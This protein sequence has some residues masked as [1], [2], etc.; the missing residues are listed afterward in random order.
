MKTKRVN[1]KVPIREYTPGKYRARIVYWEDDFGAVYPEKPS[2]AETGLTRRNL[3]LYGTSEVAVETKLKAATKRLEEKRPPKDSAAT[4]ANYA[5]AWISGSLENSS[6]GASTRETYGHL[7]RNLSE[8][9]LGK[10]PLGRITPS[11]IEKALVELRD[12]GFS[13]STRRQTFVI[14]KSLFSSAM[15][16]RLVAYDP[17]TEL[18]TPKV[19]YSEAQFFTAEQLREIIEAS[20]ASKTLATGRVVPAHRYGPFFE[21]IALTGLRKGEALALRWSDIDL[22]KK[23]LKV[24]HSLARIRGELVLGPTKNARSRRTLGLSERLV[25]LLREWRLQQ[26]EERLLAGNKYTPSNFVITT[27]LGGPVDPRNF[28]RSFQLLLK[29]LALEGNVHTLRHSAAS[30]MLSGGFSLVKVSRILGHSSISIT[31]DVYGH[32]TSEDTTEALEYL[33]EAV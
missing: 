29:E 28:L 10:R 2:T 11:Q 14:L 13:E 23:T 25:K 8:T 7:I 24:A 6:R 17:T 9:S 12:Q 31:A 33:S 32:L 22:E 21:L 19:T 20:K 3:D 16:D 1:V 30:K 18:K 26:K 4:F 27:Q 5:K 15:R